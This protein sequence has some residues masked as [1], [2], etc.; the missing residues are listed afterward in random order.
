MW[1]HT[2]T[3]VP[4]C[5][6]KKTVYRSSSVM[7]DSSYADDFPYY[8]RYLLHYSSITLT[9]E[10]VVETEAAL[11][12]IYDRSRACFFVVN[13]GPLIALASVTAVSEGM[14]CLCY[15]A[16][17]PKVF[18]D[19]A[20]LQLRSVNSLWSE[21]IFWERDTVVRWWDRS[22]SAPVLRDAESRAGH[23]PF[24]PQSAP[25]LTSRVL[26]L[27]EWLFLTL[28]SP[29]SCSSGGPAPSAKVLGIAMGWCSAG[30]NWACWWQSGSQAMLTSL[31]VVLK[32]HPLLVVPYRT[33]IF[34]GVDAATPCFCSWVFLTQVL[35]CKPARRVGMLSSCDLFGKTEELR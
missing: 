11:S 24:N 16:V 17:S 32:L 19:Q 30:R 13:N 26:V 1:A 33:G 28:V 20:S 9:H 34:S 22:G 35:Q 12:A 8:T 29:S 4:F 18:G 27:L 14:R 10:R 3:A 2:S 25:L 7:W 21:E 23:Q 6:T 5:T 31:G 15:K